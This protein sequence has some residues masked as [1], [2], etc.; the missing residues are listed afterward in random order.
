MGEGRLNQIQ[1]IHPL[2]LIP[3]TGQGHCDWYVVR[4]KIK[5]EKFVRDRLRMM[6]MDSFVPLRKRTARYNRKVKVYELPL[7]TGYTFVR[8]EKSRRNE[9][10]ALPYVQGILKTNGKDCIVHDREILWL[11]KISGTDLEVRTE[12][13]SM[14]AGD[15]VVLAVGQLAGIEGVI[16]SQRSKHEVIVALESIGMQM[17][18]QVDTAMLEMAW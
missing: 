16:L 18:I 17:T 8:F 15:R 3:M 11:Q 14:K 1:S 4:T 6:G 10:L 12:A 2:S 7:I 9:V 5:C 13:L